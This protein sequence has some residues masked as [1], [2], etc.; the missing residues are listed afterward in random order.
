MT[1]LKIFFEIDI[2]HI[3]VYSYFNDCL[4]HDNYETRIYHSVFIEAIRSGMSI[5]RMTRIQPS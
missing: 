1:L 3:L 5:Q 4:G 2:T